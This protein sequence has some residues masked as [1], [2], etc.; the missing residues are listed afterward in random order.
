MKK[1]IL[2]T[3]FLFFTQ[4]FTAQVNIGARMGMNLGTFDLKNENFS[5]NYDVQPSLS[6]LIKMD[7]DV[8]FSTVFSFRT[9]IGLVIK[10]AEVHKLPDMQHRDTNFSLLYRLNYLEVPLLLVGRYETD[11]FGN[12][13][14]GV[15]P[16]LSLGVGGKMEMFAKHL[17][18]E[19]ETQDSYS[20]VWG[21]KP[22]PEGRHNGYNYFRRFDFGLGAI[23]AYQLPRSGLTFT[24]SYNKGLRNISPND[25][26]ELRTNYYG[27]SIGFTM[28]N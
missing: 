9:G 28:Q 18:T 22:A 13:F 24:A 12:F 26:I 25:G 21:N 6:I 11:F 8:P 16:T 4:I 15:G 27:L 14:L 23:L 20:L 7:V 1:I 10:G 3:G 2:L 17:P 19:K 5:E